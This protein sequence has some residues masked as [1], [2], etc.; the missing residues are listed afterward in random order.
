MKEMDTYFL[1]LNKLCK[2]FDKHGWPEYMNGFKLGER[3]SISDD[4]YKTGWVIIEVER[5]RGLLNERYIRGVGMSNYETYLMRYAVDLN[6]DQVD[7]LE[8]KVIDRQISLD[9]AVS[10]EIHDW[11]VEINMKSIDAIRINNSKD[12]TEASFKSL[13]EA[14]SGITEIINGLDYSVC[15]QELSA[16]EI[17]QFKRKLVDELFS[18]VSESWM[19]DANY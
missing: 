12:G 3:M 5:H 6:S 1:A 18:L 9:D 16:S 7:T 17:D 4:E 13:S 11:S 15:W 2:Y 10:T 8:E 14:R 19:K